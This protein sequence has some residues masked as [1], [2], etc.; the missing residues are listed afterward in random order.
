MTSRGT[1]LTSFCVNNERPKMIMG[2]KGGVLSILSG[3]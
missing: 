3:V 1:Y 2:N